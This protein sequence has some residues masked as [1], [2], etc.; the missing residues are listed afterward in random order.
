MQ[1]MLCKGS[2]VVGCVLPF[3][4]N[5]ILPSASHCEETR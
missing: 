2:V 3:R 4:Q 5:E 1:F